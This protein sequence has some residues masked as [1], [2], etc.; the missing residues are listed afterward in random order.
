MR[1]YWRKHFI[2]LISLGYIE[3]LFRKGRKINNKVNNEKAVNRLLFSFPEIS[4]GLAEL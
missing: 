4:C 3:T 2:L 1:D